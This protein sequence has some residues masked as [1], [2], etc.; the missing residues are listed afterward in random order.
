LLRHPGCDIL[1]VVWAGASTTAREYAR[2]VTRAAVPGGDPVAGER[3]G[4]Q[5]QG[6]RSCRS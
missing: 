2:P 1:P 5:P 4:G 3:G 6:V